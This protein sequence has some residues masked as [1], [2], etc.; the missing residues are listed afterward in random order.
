MGAPDANQAMIEARAMRRRLYEFEETQ[1]WVHHVADL[2]SGEILTT[3]LD[4][5]L[6]PLSRAERLSQL[7]HPFDPGIFGWP[8]QRLTPTQ[9]YQASPLAWLFIRNCSGY[10]SGSGLPP[11]VQWHGDAGGSAEFS[12]TEPTNQR[13]LASISL[14]ASASSSAGH[15]GVRAYGGAP[16]EVPVDSTLGAHTVDVVFVTT[17]VIPINIS[18]D[19]F[20]GVEVLYFKGI[21]FGPA[22]PVFEG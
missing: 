4:R 8:S 18:I 11:F 19:S 17:D 22:E 16:I 15:L 1:R 5:P 13:C 14:S 12:F 21:S 6:A 3:P 20:V 7:G 10:S 9:P 2:D